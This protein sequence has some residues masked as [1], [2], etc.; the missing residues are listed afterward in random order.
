MDATISELG[1]PHRLALRWVA[2]R[3]IDRWRIDDR[4]LDFLVSRGLVSRDRDQSL[5]LTSSGVRALMAIE[6]V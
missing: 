3:N 4:A 2:G 1:M 6:G 5:E